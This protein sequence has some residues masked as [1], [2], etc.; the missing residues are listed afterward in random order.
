MPRTRATSATVIPEPLHTFYLHICLGEHNTRTLARK[1][2]LS[3]ATCSRLL[4]RLRPI[5]ARRGEELVSVRSRGRWHYDIRA[6]ALDPFPAG[7]GTVREWR[8][9]AGRKDDEL[10]YG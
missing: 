8:R 6:S 10:I 9:P 1:L 4:R 5:L 2:R 7:F 3:T